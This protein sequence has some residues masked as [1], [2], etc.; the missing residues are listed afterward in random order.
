VHFEWD[1]D[2]AVANL[3]KH[4]ISFDEATTGTAHFQ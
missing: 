3:K 4:D 2:K 1:P